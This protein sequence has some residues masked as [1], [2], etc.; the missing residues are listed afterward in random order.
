MLDLTGNGP[1][2]YVRLYATYDF[3]N[4]HAL[5]LTFAPLQVDGTGSLSDDVTFRDDVFTAD[6]PTEGTYKFNIYRLTY[7]WT[8]YDR[9]RWR[10]GLGAA[11]LVRDA[12]ITL[13]QGDKKQTR[14]DLGVVP[15]L[16]L[17]S[18]YRFNDQVLVIL[19]V[20]A[21]GRQWDEPSMPPP[22]RLH[23]ISIRDGTWGPDTGRSRGGADHNEVYTFA[24]LHYALA[25]AGYRF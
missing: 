13:E 25:E 16:H 11:A 8:F 14:D 18:A 19:D 15:L 6:A 22:S 12:H 2:P 5:R 9:E 20:E 24:W 10:W 1:D 4:R 7:R 3:N 21:R 23:T 17:Y